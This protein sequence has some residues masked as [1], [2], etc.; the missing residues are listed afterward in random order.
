M[1]KKTNF[2]ENWLNPTHNGRLS[3]KSDFW[4]SCSYC[5]KK[6]DSSSVTETALKSHKER[7][8]HNEIPPLIKASNFFPKVTKVELVL[9]KLLLYELKNNAT[10]VR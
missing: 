3:K 1:P 10:Q 7:K 8:K 5:F 6:I 2:L 4:R 9:M